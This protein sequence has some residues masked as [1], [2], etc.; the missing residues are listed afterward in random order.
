MSNPFEKRATEYLRDDE[1]FL[2]VVTPAPLFT[3]FEPKAKD[4]V[5]FD[6][7]VVVMGTPGSGK[8]TIATL[9]QYK[10]MLTLHR[11]TGMENRRE[12]MLALSRCGAMRE[13]EIAICGCRLPLESE[14]RDF[15][16]LPYPE[17][18][19]TGLMHSLLQARAVISW[20]QSLRED[21]A[22][23]L[24]EIEIDPKDP[25]PGRIEQIGGTTGASVYARACEVE[26]EIYRIGAALVAP[27]LDTIS[28]LALD[29]YSPFEVIEKLKVRRAGSDGAREYQPLVILDD[30]HSLHP[31]QVA[32]L[33]R[34]LA[35]REQKTSRWVLMRLDSQT[36]QATLLDSFEDEQSE[37]T[38]HSPKVA[39]EVT[40][41]WLQR[42][43]DRRTQRTQFRVMA[44]QMADRYL[45]LMETFNRSGITSLASL[46]DGPGEPIA[47]G[48]E[49]ELSK[50]V[51]RIQEDLRIPNLVRNDIE[52]EIATYFEGANSNDD[53]TDVRLAML[54][55]LMYRFARRTPQVGLFEEEEL[56]PSRPILANA[57]IADGARVQLM[58]EYNRSYYF[59]MDTLC[60]GASENAELF[61]Q[62]AGRLVSLCETRIIRSSRP[63][64]SLPPSLQHKELRQK[65]AEMIDEWRFPERKRVR[66]LVDGIAAECVEKTVEATASLGG[67]PNAFGIPQ[68]EFQKIPSEYPRLAEVLKYGVGYNAIHVKQD[69]GTKHATWCLVELGGIAILNHRLSFRRGNFLERTSKDL[70]RLIADE[71]A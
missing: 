51:L 65:A 16:E 60:D 15:W 39:R 43:D 11:T 42:K 29:A 5:L 54:R 2:S 33:L 9:L 14:Y 23:T 55:I 66:L 37:E 18:V 48:H 21:H 22:Y 67:G 17:G 8:T 3:F 62:L 28:R 31:Q 70:A 56:E 61:L 63:G 10:T 4:G 47:S 45:R 19:R 52:K 49:R 44:R 1:A 13:G 50:R 6:R 59:G 35:R 7:L 38:D 57:G 68:E 53:N 20:L 25:S 34:W 26:R 32:G 46:L 12:L 24:D 30:A 69:H 71:M 41:I 64:P 58:H 27:K 40:T 36:P